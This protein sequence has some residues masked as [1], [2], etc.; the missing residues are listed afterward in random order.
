M[1]AVP[2]LCVMY[3]G[4]CLITEEKSRK[5]PQSGNLKVSGLISAERDSFSGLG[6]HLALA[7]TDLL[8][9]AALGF[10]VRRQGSAFSQR[11]YLPRFP[12]RGFP[13][14]PNVESKLAVRAVM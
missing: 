4:I 13:T 11:M 10:H 1:R 9:P 3:P 8:T 2:R 12:T 14:S 6:H 5:Q 7:S